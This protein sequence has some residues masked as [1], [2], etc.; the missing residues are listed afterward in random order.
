[1]N[2]PFMPGAVSALTVVVLG[3]LP[4]VA[5]A[6]TVQG[7]IP[8]KEVQGTVAATEVLVNVE[9]VDAP[10][11][12]ME[13][14]MKSFPSGH[15]PFV[16]VGA[17]RAALLACGATDIQGP[18]VRTPDS[19]S[20]RDW[21]PIQ[22]PTSA[23]SADPFSANSHEVDNVLDASPHINSDGTITLAYKIKRGDLPTSKLSMSDDQFF[24]RLP[25]VRT[26]KAGIPQDVML[27]DITPGQP[28]VA[29]VHHF[30]YVTASIVPVNQI[31]K[32]K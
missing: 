25:S 15:L 10:Q 17:A 31:T 12:V 22:S 4:A 11:S 16:N 27:A 24:R 21:Q 13:K 5:R 19:V 9:F 6:Q 29:P 30:T 26:F 18:Q 23:K 20:R 14:A 8:I 7:A 28:G 32:S 2:N 1:M 3:F